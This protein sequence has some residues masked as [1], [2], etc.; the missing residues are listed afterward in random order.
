MSM[1]RSDSP[2]RGWRLPGPAVAVGWLALATAPLLAAH[3]TGKSLGHVWSEL[4]AGLALFSA[5]LLIQQFLSSGRYER[6]SGAIGLDRTMGFHRLTGLSVLIAALAHPLAYV[7]PLILEDPGAAMSRL[8]AML[9]SPHLRSGVLSLGVLLLLVAFAIVRTRPFVRY[10]LW[11]AT[12]SL[13]AV[14]AAGFMLHHAMTAGVY[15]TE[16]PLRE[17]WMGYAAVAAGSLAVTWIIRPPLSRTGGWR[18]TAVEPRGDGIW[19]LT[20]S[21]S[22]TAGFSFRGGQFVWL[23]VGSERH[24]FED[25]PFS[26]ISA[27]TE[28]PRLRFLIRESG[29]FSSRVGSLSPGAPAAVDGPHGSFVIEPDGK[30]VVMIAG[31][32]GIAPVLGML[33]ERMAAGDPRPFRLLYAAQDATRLPARARLEAIAHKLDLKVTYLLEHDHARQGAS[34]GTVTAAH[35]S[36]LIAGLPRDMAA[37]VCGPPR[38]MEIAGDALLA[39]G[40]PSASIHYERFDYAAGRGRLDV[41]R[42]NQALALMAVAGGLL[43]AFALR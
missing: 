10:E 35:C 37:Y 18:V 32:V 20:I 12:H 29:D 3:L 41:R 2:A 38:L 14:A 4:G 8:A 21:A 33:E 28:L 27:A 16:T 11:R 31:G 26:I 39:A 5:A 9:Q 13:L 42:R 36:E 17:L 1:I 19:E 43:A 25:H 6:I 24:W 23:K 30:A 34:T 40:V 15:S 22:S 7:A